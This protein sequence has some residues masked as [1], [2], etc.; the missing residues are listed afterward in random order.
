LEFTDLVSPYSLLNTGVYASCL[1]L[2]VVASLALAGGSESPA[3]LLGG[4]RSCNR[5]LLAA[6]SEYT[7]FPP[8]RG[9]VGYEHRVEGER[10]AYL[11]LLIRAYS[12]RLH[13][14]GDDHAARHGPTMSRTA[15]RALR[16]ADGRASPLPAAYLLGRMERA[17][18][19][20][21]ES[22]VRAAL[23]GAIVACCQS[24]KAVLSGAEIPAQTVCRAFA[25]MDGAL[26]D[27]V[28]HWARRSTRPSLDPKAVGPNTAQRT[29][30]PQDAKGIVRAARA[31][32]VFAET[33]H[34]LSASSHRPEAGAQRILSLVRRSSTHLT[35]LWAYY[36]LSCVPEQILPSA[37]NH[38]SGNTQTPFNEST[39]DTFKERK[40]TFER[41]IDAAEELLNDDHIALPAMERVC[42]ALKRAYTYDP[43]NRAD[44]LRCAR[45]LLLADRV[46]P[47]ESEPCDDLGY[48]D[49]Q[50]I[51]AMPFLRTNP[52]GL[53]FGPWY[54][55]EVKA[56]GLTPAATTMRHHRTEM[57]RALM[58]RL[59]AGEK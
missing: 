45:V 47:S 17:R 26:L 55:D 11:S 39:E 31:L 48:L 40:G 8:V 7:P 5:Q 58:R 50:T 42:A 54:R 13:S 9:T 15:R 28:R 41:A 44:L 10:L 49:D 25:W 46:A 22:D 21:E 51:A 52:F 53:L 2:A 18:R 19:V 34:S 1:I 27:E 12:R 38:G 16:A 43:R 35:A 36:T 20:P 59:G 29:L 57:C 32:N 30:T 33:L 56:R 4:L 14:E 23:Y 3:A 24:A 37:H 6:G